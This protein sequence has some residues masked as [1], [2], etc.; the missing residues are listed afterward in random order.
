MASQSTKKDVVNAIGL[1]RS[2]EKSEDGEVEFWY[3]TGK[4]IST[5]Y[6]VPMPTSSTPYSPGVDLVNYADLGAKNVVGN[7]PVVLVCMF[8]RAGQLVK[9][10]KPEQK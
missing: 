3:Y 2:A 1:P 10:Y 5:S 7:Q 9:I 4:P 8:N 6:F